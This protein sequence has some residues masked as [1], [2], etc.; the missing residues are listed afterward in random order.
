MRRLHEI[1]A[2]LVDGVSFA[3]IN[4]LQWRGRAGDHGPQEFEAYFGPL[5][6]RS[7]EEVFAVPERVEWEFR[8][9]GGGHRLPTPPG[10]ESDCPENNH[11]HLDIWP[12]PR[13][14]NS[15]VMFLL[16]GFMSVSDIGYRQWAK[17][18]NRHGWTA[19]FFHL[20]YH[21]GRR[22]RGVMSG[23][24]ALSSNLIRTA[25][26]IRQSVIEL[27]L[28]ARLF[29]ERGA[30]H[31]GLWA[32]SYGGW[33]GSLVLLLESSV[34]TAWLLEPI[35]DVDHAIWESPAGAMIRRRLR[36]RGIDRDRVRHAL[37]HFC[38]SH[39]QPVMDSSKILLLAG[40]YDRVAPPATI[41]ALHTRWPGSHYA[42][43][44]QGHVGYQL[45]PASLRMAR[46]KFPEMFDG[47]V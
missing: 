37:E 4:A 16:H 2:R 38:P 31:A 33:V 27:R 24:M 18:L 20:P 6:G 5:R 29:R 14:W 34:G 17:I 22:P 26:G 46:E 8:E 19:V 9:G 30:P 13:G 44:P 40:S 39:H 11:T 32:T 25:A 36:R 42:E 45:M 43:L 35:A 41:R 47:G 12:G 23:E 28:A 3:M 1:Q 21:Y 7:L 10:S 15:P